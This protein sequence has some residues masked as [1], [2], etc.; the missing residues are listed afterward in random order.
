MKSAPSEEDMAAPIAAAQAEIDLP[1]GCELVEAPFGGVVWK[2]EIAEGSEVAGGQTVAIIEAM[3]MESPVASPLGGVVRRIY[4]SERQ[5]VA[6]GA[7][8]FALETRP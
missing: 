7:P 4:V 1:E 2:L 3:K 5:Q 8:L 6:P